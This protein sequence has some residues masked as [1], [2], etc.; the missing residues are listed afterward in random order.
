MTE[1]VAWGARTKYSI[2][3]MAL[4]RGSGIQGCALLT[5]CLLQAASLKSCLIE[6]SQQEITAQADVPLD[7]STVGSEIPHFFDPPTPSVSRGK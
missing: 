3:K 5:G 7:K 1:G 4:N 6:Y 2:K